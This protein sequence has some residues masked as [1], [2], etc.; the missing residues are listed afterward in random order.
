[1]NT[2]IDIK[3]I[4]NDYDKDKSSTGYKIYSRRIELNINRRDFSNMVGISKNTLVRY[5][6]GQTHPNIEK[7]SRI[8]NV[9]CVELYELYDDYYKK[10][11]N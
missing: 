9:L 6:R 8:A 10:Q 5:E 7:L 2:N 11:N 4:K 1:M 3:Y